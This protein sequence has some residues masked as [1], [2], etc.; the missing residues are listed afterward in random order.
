MRNAVCMPRVVITSSSSLLATSLLFL[1]V[2]AP[3][4]AEDETT[5]GGSTSRGDG[6]LSFPDLRALIKDSLAEVIR[7]NPTLLRPP[8]SEEVSAGELCERS[9]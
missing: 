7:D 1:F 3:I 4:M 9:T 5:A 6:G 8:P 2:S